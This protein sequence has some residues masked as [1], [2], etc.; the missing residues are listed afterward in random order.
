MGALAY[1]RSGGVGV[2]KRI[3]KPVFMLWPPVNELRR[4]T[5]PAT[6][7]SSHEV[8]LRISSSACTIRTFIYDDRVKGGNTLDES[9]KLCEDPIM[10]HDG[11]TAEVLIHKA[12]MQSINSFA[13]LCYNNYFEAIFVF[14]NFVFERKVKIFMYE[15]NWLCSTGKDE[16]WIKL[17]LTRCTEFNEKKSE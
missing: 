4:W 11:H 1:I 12:R 13:R 15:T 2:I 14:H 8:S 3:I 7:A 16:G 9:C 10:H 17:I 5:P 6:A